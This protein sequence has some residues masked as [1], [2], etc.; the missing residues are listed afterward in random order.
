MKLSLG[1]LLLAAA[2][3]Q[4]AQ[5]GPCSVT[6]SGLLSG[7][8]GCFAQGSANGDLVISFDGGTPD[9]ESTIHAPGMPVAGAVYTNTDPGALGHCDVGDGFWIA[10][11]AIDEGP[12]IGTYRLSLSSVRFRDTN[13]DGTPASSFLVVHGSLD[14]HIEE[15]F[16]GAGPRLA[17]VHATF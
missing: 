1:L 17:E 7:T 12:S 5:H 15:A 14:C 11:T 9:F 3:G 2:C 4:A 13:P 16:L 8:T 6:Y 10:R